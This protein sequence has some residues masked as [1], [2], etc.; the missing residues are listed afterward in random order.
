[1]SL[2]SPRWRLAS[3]HPE[4]S[5]DTI[6]NSSLPSE[7]A[8]STKAFGLNCPKTLQRILASN[9]W[10]TMSLTSATLTTGGVRVGLH[11]VMKY[12]ICPGVRS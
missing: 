12:V 11:A 3:R 5:P 9:A 10:L 2:R 6:L 1:M 8:L 4:R 7:K